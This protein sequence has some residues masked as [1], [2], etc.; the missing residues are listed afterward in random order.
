MRRLTGLLTIAT[1]IGATL[2]SM[3]AFATSL[4]PL[5]PIYDPTYKILTIGVGI[6]GNSPT[7]TV[8]FY[9]AGPDGPIS[10]GRVTVSQGV[11]LL[12]IPLFQSGT[13]AGA[14][15]NGD[16]ANSFTHADFRIYWPST[17]WL[18]VV[19]KGD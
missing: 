17:D 1:V 15:Y 10:L 11:A 7:G 6:D 3:T 9:A 8:D 16:A 2:F 18:P 4:I 5:A 13:L 14:T 19:L 12:Q